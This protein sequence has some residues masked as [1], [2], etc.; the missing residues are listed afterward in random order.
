MSE[1]V[2]GVAKTWRRHILT[3]GR[4]VGGLRPHQEVF[5]RRSPEISL[6]VDSL[7]V[8]STDGG[9]QVSEI[10][11]GN[12]PVHVDSKEKHSDTI[13]ILS[14]VPIKVSPD[15]PVQVTLRNDSD[16]IIM[17]ASALFRGVVEES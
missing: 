3:M 9:V 16:E 5:L 1:E 12:A 17:N 14:F 15:K 4:L 7:V 13:W 11:N 8:A 10:L 2:E 6:L